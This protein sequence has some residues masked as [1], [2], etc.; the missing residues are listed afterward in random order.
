VQLSRFGHEASLT[1]ACAVI[2]LVF[3]VRAVRPREH[4]E[5]IGI[6]GSRAGPTNSGVVAANSAASGSAIRTAPCA[7][8]GVVLAISLYSYGSMRVFMPSMVLAGGLIF[9]REL[10]ERWRVRD[11][12]RAMLAGVAAFA[13]TAAPL[14]YVH[15]TRWELVTARARQVSVFHGAVSWGSAVSEAVGN[16]AAHFSPTWLVTRGDPSIALSPRASGQLDPVVVTF[17]FIG[18]VVA[19][20]RARA[21]RR[22]AV[23][24][25]WLMLHPLTASLTVDGP[26]ALRS[27]C[28]LPV[29]PWLAAIGCRTVIA[30]FS[31]SNSRRPAVNVLCLAGMLFAAGRN[32]HHYFLEWSRDPV[33]TSRYQAD[34]CA[35]MRAIRP[36]VADH[37]RVF[38]SDQEDAVRRW[39]SGEPYIIALLLLPVDPADFQRWDKSVDYYSV[40]SIGHALCPEKGSH[41]GW[42]ALDGG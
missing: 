42:I 27:A 23:P 5:T 30:Q 36:L 32:L 31:G 14:V 11:A 17:T 29:F 1:P 12:R 41:E 6:D 26:H 16:Y 3:I 19:I 38:V 24:L 18:V 15:A 20:G 35:A 28:G 40:N 33:V 34:L 22:F 21:Q 10:A 39:H 37:D 7:A 2:G 25:A 4:G 9:R 13:V 8:A